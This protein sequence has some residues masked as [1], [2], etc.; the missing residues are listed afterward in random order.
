MAPKRFRCFVIGC[1]NEHSSRHLLPTSER[2]KAQWITF[3]F[4]GNARII[5]YTAV[6]IEQIRHKSVHK[7]SVPDS[8]TLL[9]L[10]L[11][12]LRLI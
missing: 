9:L 3:A 11:L 10:L 6:Y 2:L 7:S 4:K 8:D 5:F 1:K 12:L